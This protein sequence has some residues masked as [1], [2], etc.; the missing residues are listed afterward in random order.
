[1]KRRIIPLKLQRFNIFIANVGGRFVEV[2]KSALQWVKQ[3][4]SGFKVCFD[5]FLLVKGRKVAA[6]IHL[7]VRENL[8][9]FRNSGGKLAKILN[10]KLLTNPFFDFLVIEVE[11]KCVITH[12]QLHYKMLITLLTLLNGF[13]QRDHK[14]VVGL[15]GFFQQKHACDRLVFD[16][17]FVGFSQHTKMRIVHKNVVFPT[18]GHKLAH[19]FVEATYLIAHGLFNTR[20]TN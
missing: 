18:W 6:L 1:M 9:D 13:C 19:V 7:F 5:C 2:E 17:V 8:E 4:V 20:G 14:K 11:F 3:S 12:F 15:L 16:L 10:L